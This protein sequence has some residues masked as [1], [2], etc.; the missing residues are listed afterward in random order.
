MGMGC[1]DGMS[2]CHDMGMGIIMQCMQHLEKHRSRMH[3]YG[4]LPERCLAH[5]WCLEAERLLEAE[6]QLEVHEDLQCGVVGTVRQKQQ[7][8]QLYM[9]R[10][11]HL[12]VYVY[13]RIKTFL[14]IAIYT[15]VDLCVTHLCMYTYM[16]RLVVPCKS[17]SKHISKNISKRIMHRRKH[18]HKHRQ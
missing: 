10:H 6:R 3:R 12:W 11:I 7:R 14:L 18:Q 16:R 2:R 13:V 8:Y 4:G 15:Y 1:F 17:I 9:Y 5:R